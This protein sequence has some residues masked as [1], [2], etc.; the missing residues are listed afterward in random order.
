MDISISY[1]QTILNENYTRQI[2]NHTDFQEYQPR[3]EITIIVL[4]KL[5][6]FIQMKRLKAVYIF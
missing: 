3:K 2:F 6:A 1:F 4:V 5:A